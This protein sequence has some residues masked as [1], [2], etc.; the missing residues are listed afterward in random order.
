MSIYSGSMATR[1]PKNAAVSA[2]GCTSFQLH[3]SQMSLFDGIQDKIVDY[4]ERRLMRY[5]D[6]VSDQQQR[7]VLMAMIVDYQR[8]Y[9][10]IAWK[11]GMPVA[12][13]V[14]KDT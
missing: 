8:G 13:K 12:I 6:A 9:V 1:N 10:A 4:T 14:T 7:M 2:A 11:R 5:A 3:K